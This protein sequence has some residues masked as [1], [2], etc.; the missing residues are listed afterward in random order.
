MVAGIQVVDGKVAFASRREPAWHGL[1]TV[2]TEDKSTKEIMDLAYL[3]DW[4][5]RSKSY[6][7]LMPSTWDT[8]LNKSMIIRDNPFYDREAEADALV[9]GLP[10]DEKPVNLLGD[11]SDNYSIMQN[12]ELFEFGALFGQRWETAGAIKNGTVVF[13]T[14]ALETETVID[15]TGAND[16]IK[17]YLMLT[18]SHDG[19]LAL[20]VGVTPIRV[21][22][23]NTLNMALPG[24]KSRIKL[25]HT[26]T[27]SER[28][29]KAKLT[30][31][32][33]VKYMHKFNDDAKEL[34]EAPV[35]DNEFWAIVNT[36]NPEPEDNKKGS[37]TKWTK[38][39]D[40]IMELWNGATQANIAGTGWAAL[41][42]LTEEQQWNRSVYGENL[43]NFFVAGAGLD[44]AANTKRDEIHNVVRELVLNK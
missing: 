12:E 33:A 22:C 44:D 41:N 24:L 34:F 7:D 20:I 14:L 11:A 21:V 25:R 17:Q 8:H 39:T 4:N 38:K 31:E 13:G 3:S 15:P 6:K 35:N 43:E 26:K 29:E 30:A 9:N 27:M 23:Q 10:Y 18:T 16:V 40:A 5:I 32:F 2:F 19:T 36:L 28:L 42:A 1:G 37:R